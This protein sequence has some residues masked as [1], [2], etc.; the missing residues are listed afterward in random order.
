MSIYINKNNQQSGPYED[1]IVIDQLRNG[2]LSPDDLAIRHG[3]TTWQRLGD[4][5]PEAHPPGT[6]LP[7]YFVPQ[8]GVSSSEPPSKKGGCRKPLGWTVFGIGLL[9]MLV[10]AAVA[11]ATP[12]AYSTLSCDFAEMDMKKVD[13]LTKKYEAAKG[14]D[15]EFSVEYELKSALAGSEQSAKICA[16]QNSTKNMFQ[17]GS[18]AVAF[19]GFLMALV[20]FFVR[21][22]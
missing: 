8:P 1:R 17:I 3:G 14:T 9:V 16:E 6:E 7:S 13:E 22:V 12:F 11:I 4:I 10:G 15:E 18:I 20:G 2:M 21:R 19:V 5:F